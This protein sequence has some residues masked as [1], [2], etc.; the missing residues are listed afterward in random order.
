ML[1]IPDLNVTSWKSGSLVFRNTP[2]K[3]VL[4]DLEDYYGKK[5]ML[6]DSSLVG[7]DLTAEFN[8]RELY[9][10]IEMMEFMLNIR[11]IASGDT[12]QI[13]PVNSDIKE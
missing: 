6:T 8:N 1:A 9:E 4:H 3:K 5:Y 11:I 7:Y 12:L 2:L 10:V 13:A